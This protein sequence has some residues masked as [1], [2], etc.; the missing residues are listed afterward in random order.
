MLFHRLCLQC[1]QVKHVVSPSLLSSQPPSSGL[2]S[3]FG[4]LD[5]LQLVDKA[6]H[7]HLKLLLNFF[8]MVSHT[9][10]STSAFYSSSAHTVSR[11]RGTKERLHSEP[12]DGNG[13]MWGMV[14]N[15]MASWKNKSAPQRAVFC[16]APLWN[17]SFLDTEIHI[18]HLWKLAKQS[19]VSRKIKSMGSPQ[20]TYSHCSYFHFSSISLYINIFNQI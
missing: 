1:G 4:P 18:D 8:P 5:A 17:V 14:E 9:V 10:S 13:A 6:S 2:L 16:F 15:R 12:L 3:S 7:L 19:H 20:T 11:N